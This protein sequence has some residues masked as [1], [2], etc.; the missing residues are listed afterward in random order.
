MLFSFLSCSGQSA[1]NQVF[2]EVS[3]LS[4]VRFDKDLHLYLQ[5]ADNANLKMLE[6]KY[7]NFLPAFGRITINNSDSYKPE[8]YS[9]LKQYFSNQ[10][11][12]KIYDDA[13]NK[14]ADVTPYEKELAIADNSISEY[15]PGKKLPM[16]FTHVSGFKENV[17]ILN[18]V[19]S[20]ST[21]KYLGSDYPAYK[22][23]F[24]DYQRIQMQPEM[25]VRDYLKA[26]LLSDMVQAQKNPS[27]LDG[28]IKEGK[29]LYI[30]S[31]LL[32]DWTPENLISY[33]TEQ[34]TWCKDNEK[35]IWNT[36]VKKNHLFEQDYQLIN[37][38][39]NE[40]PYT[41]T[42]TT[43]SPGRVGCWLGWQ[44][45]N[46]YISNNKVSLSQLITD[47]AQQILKNAGYNP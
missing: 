18:G 27:L 15:F 34:L 30:L 37:K 44:I 5:N 45:I 32:P 2:E 11:L 10:M 1:N 14:F 19:I 40:A 35:T 3:T 31:K 33:T 9:R 17:I 4:I 43:E 24:E 39:V 38:Y 8:F 29:V 16:L 28:I 21:D 7:K 22:Q 36:V 25:I 13:L 46:S 6:N 41:A 12:S 42:L 26:W 47:D 20:I 23:F